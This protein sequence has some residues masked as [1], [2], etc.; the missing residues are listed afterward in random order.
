M[1]SDPTKRLVKMR[2]NGG[3]YFVLPCDKAY[4]IKDILDS[5]EGVTLSWVIA[6]V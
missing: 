6:D 3:K 5:L 2:I 4:Q 1:I